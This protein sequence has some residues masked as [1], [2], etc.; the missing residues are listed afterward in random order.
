MEE[1]LPTTFADKPTILLVDDEESILNSLRRLLRGQPYE[2]LLATSGE[3]ALDIMAKQPVDLVMSDARMPNMDGATLLAHIHQRHPDTLRILLTGYADLTMIVKAINDGQIDRYISKPW[4]DEELL[5]TLRQS[6]AYQRSERERLHLVQETWEQNE[7]LRLLNATLEKH[8]ASRTAE[9]QQT[10]DMLDLA[11]EELKH[12]YVTGTEVFSLLANLRL[13]PAKQT[14][15]QII[16]LVRVYCKLHGVD[17][18][19]TRDLT[20]A[21]ALYNIGKLSWTDSMMTAPADLLHHNDQERYRGYP[22]QSESLL[23]TLDPMKDA[24]RLILHHQE[25]WDGT[26]FPD[27]LKGEAIPLGA[28]W[29]KLAVDFIELQRGLILERQM[30]SDEALVYIRQYAGRLY[31]PDLVEDFIQVCAAYQSDVSLADPTVKVLTTR[32]L[33]TGMILAR[34]LNA[35]NG[36]LLLNAGKVLS[37][38]LVEKLIAFEAMEGAKY[39]VF[40]KVPEEVEAAI[41]EAPLVVQ[42]QP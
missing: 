31:D 40:V 36:M 21:A 41:L 3:Q 34:N 11:Y 16:E 39:S 19:S 2:V 24:A 32:D 30:N 10:A 14:N 7:E 8:V 1:Q 13:P 6:L 9:L 23:M 26:G 12:S 25:R 35:D 20:M 42:T 15:R 22:K 37:G 18:G 28:R 4:H 29:L 27:R 5:L 17:E 38:P 33:A